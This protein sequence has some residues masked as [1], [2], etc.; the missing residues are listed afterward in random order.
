MATNTD[1]YGLLAAQTRR[2]ACDRCHK[3]KL[4]C[5][6]SPIFADGNLVLLPL[7]T[8]K[9]CEKAGAQCQ[10]T[11][12]T[13]TTTAT[14]GNVINDRNSTKRK[15][16]PIE[17]RDQNR[18]PT[19]QPTPAPSGAENDL[20]S[21]FSQSPFNH[22]LGESLMFNIDATA[23]LDLEGFESDGNDF[24][25]I[26]GAVTAPALPSM[27][28][29]NRHRSVARENRSD[30]YEPSASPALSGAHKNGVIAVTTSTLTPH[31]GSPY[32]DSDRDERKRVLELH[33]LV[34]DGLHHITESELA[35]S[36]LSSDG[37]APESLNEKALPINIIGRV[38]TTSERILEFLDLLCKKLSSESTTQL[39]E[40]PSD[41]RV[42]SVAMASRYEDP[43]L[44]QANSAFLC[45]QPYLFPNRL[46]EKR[47]DGEQP[48]LS[49]S[50]PSSQAVCVPVLISF[51]TCYV[52]LLSAYRAIFAHIQTMLRM[53]DPAPSAPPERSGPQ[54][55][56]T[57]MSQAEGST[58][59]HEQILRI[60]IQVEV[61]THMLDR[62][63]QAWAAFMNDQSGDESD[64]GPS[65]KAAA[66]LLLQSMFMHE[67]FDCRG[68][69]LK[70]GLRSL[71]VSLDGIRRMLRGGRFV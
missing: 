32:S 44:G 51:L 15:T 3:H 5:E 22:S 59:N 70:I 50:T 4:R 21:I 46:A 42:G 10:T 33:T 43:F 8:C 53:A 23:M 54:S 65:Y 27:H 30:V 69:G 56:R 25:T 66:M 61:M 38:L 16:P 9:R 49:P 20:L 37:T 52:G 24:H 62:I 39:Y 48:M 63:G 12:T 7:G 28:S 64:I 2:F 45:G 6:R 1:S 41:Q 58:L 68:E 26:M 11:T 34:F 17:M 19:P 71:E 29:R 14:A 55:K 35:K 47:L 31:S 40:T 18:T 60:R 13:T 36:I 57:S 67:G